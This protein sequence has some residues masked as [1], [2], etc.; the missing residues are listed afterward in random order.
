MEEQK[1]MKLKVD[2]T[3][4]KEMFRY[5]SIFKKDFL[6]LCGFMVGLAGMDIVFPL[7]TRY[8]IDNF[9]ANGDYNGLTL[10]GV[11]Y[12]ILAL[13]LGLIVFLFIRHAGKIEMGIVYKLRKD[14][15]EK[16]QR[17]SFSYY[18][19][20]AVGWMI[21]RTT[22]DA[23]KISETVAWGVVDLVW[24]ATMMLGVSV[25]MLIINW[26]LALVTLITVPVLAVVS[27]FFEKK[28]LVSYRNVRKINS[29][30]TGLFNDG[31]VG[32]KT[33]KTLVREE[34]N[35]EEFQDVTK[36][37]KKTSIRAATLSAGY[38]PMTLFISAVGTVLTLLLGSNFL[39]DGALTYGTLVLF[40]TYARQFF[41]PIL[42]IARIYTEM[43]GAQAAAER[44]M[45]LLHEKE[46]IVDT[47]VEEKEDY[48]K[49]HGDVTFENVSFFYKEGEY[50]LKNFNL[51]VKAG[52]TIALVGETGSGKSTIVNLACRFYEPSE[53]KI[54]I[55]GEDYKKRPQSW[56][57]QNIGYVLQA[58]HLFSGTIKENIRYGKLAAT[59]EDIIEAAKVVHAHDF[60]MKLEKGY[61]T[62]VG[63]G[64][65]MLST[66][67]KQLISFAR[68]IIGKPRLF[69]LDEATSSIDTE[70]EAKIQKA[71]EEVLENRT[72]FI[73]AH[74]LS[75]IKNA[76]RI[77]V[78][79]QGEILEEGNHEELLKKRGHYY[80]LYTN[81]FV[82]E[83]GREV[84][85]GKVV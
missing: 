37:M 10:V 46:E 3:V 17:L 31:I 18:D 32:A 82:E 35:I 42:E 23:T 63:E 44:V 57:H 39:M 16:L 34:L 19:K 85:K 24:G 64:G 30:I 14:A 15:F 74:R 13:G 27:V 41:D 54:L 6:I 4:W 66:G 33:T 25:V 73:V 2:K 61:D 51:Q 79:D 26:K 38:L 28:M 45:G 11:L 12:G 5:L 60:I 65:G 21:A 59:D 69:F 70:S 52:E 77:L 56:L 9:V 84:L 71:I 43:I 47:E 83:A 20:N 67:E 78:I 72:S 50:I 7:L 8:A 62:E 80:E 81:Q 53:G 49:I 1:E 58:P 75:T 29:K 36:D 68:A 40:I 48:G 76:D 22:S 55:D